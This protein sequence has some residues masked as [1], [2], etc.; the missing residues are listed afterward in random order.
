LD[1]IK[2]LSDSH[3]FLSSFGFRFLRFAESTSNKHASTIKAAFSA[4][5]VF[6]E[7]DGNT[8][9]FFRILKYFR[10]NK[11]VGFALFIAQ[12]SLDYY[13]L[14]LICMKKVFDLILDKI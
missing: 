9:L 6:L 12:I 11:S 10:Q 2:R 8:T 13:S 7:S 5:E 14:I 3:V 4:A 1:F